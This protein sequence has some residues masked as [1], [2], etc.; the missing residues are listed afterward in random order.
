M[1]SSLGVAGL[2]GIVGTFAAVLWTFVLRLG[3][4]PGSALVLWGT[5]R[6]ERWLVHLGT[7]V[8]F[9]V[10]AYLLLAF[11]AM[12]NRIVRGYLLPRPEAVAWPLWLVGWYLATAPL[13]FSGRDPPGAS[14]RDAAD[15]ALSAAL[16][17][18]LVGY[19]VFVVWP[20]V[21][22]AGWGWLPVV[23]L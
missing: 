5:R 2:L 22:E 13:L 10:E 20:G 16:P 1:L 9:L 6:H 3:A 19:W 18:V 14:A 7:A 11:V 23:S 21:L 4:Y 15:V 12:V 8:S 17:L